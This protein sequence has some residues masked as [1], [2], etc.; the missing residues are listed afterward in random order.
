MLK[1][2]IV[3]SKEYLRKKCMDAVRGSDDV[4]ICKA[5]TAA[6]LFYPIKTN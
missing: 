5:S 3:A 2:A 4:M 1:S 6:Y